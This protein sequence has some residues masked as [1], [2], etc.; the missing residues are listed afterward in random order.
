MY[1][2]TVK[3][4]ARGTFYSDPKDPHNTKT[5]HMWYSLSNGSSTSSYGFA[6]EVTE[7]DGPGKI[8]DNDDQAYEGTYYTGKIVIS[9][10]QYNKLKAFGNKDNLDGK[11]FDFSSYYNGLNNSCVDY[12][13]KA[14][15]I[16]GI[17]LSDFEG[18]AS[19][20]THNADSADEA[21]YKYLTG[22]TTGWDESRPDSGGYDVIYGSKGNDTLKSN[23][24]TDAIYG[25]SGNDDIYGNSTSEKLYGG[26]GADFIDGDSGND[27]LVGNG[28][29]D[30]LIGGKGNDTYI[31]ANGDTIMDSDHSGKVYLD[32]KWLLGGKL[33][34]GETNKYKGDYGEIYTLD[35]L[36]DTLHVKLNG[37]SITI[38]NYNE[39]KQSLGIS[40]GKEIEVTVGN[41]TVYED[42]GMMRVAVSINHILDKDITFAM[43]S[44]QASATESEDY[45]GFGEKDK[46]LGQVTIKAGQTVGY[47]DIP[48]VNDEIIEKDETFNIVALPDSSL[49]TNQ[50]PL[51]IKYNGDDLAKVTFTNAGVG[52]IQDDDKVI[53][54]IVDNISTCS[55]HV[56]QIKQTKKVA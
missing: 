9:Q 15:N 1:S 18:Q 13:W 6:P 25:G 42:A 7:M 47:I 53:F 22:S 2:V 52:T 41:S 51:S 27:T 12:V 19:F 49:D 26:D 50:Y 31:S 8:W 16:I 10:A 30:V 56:E 43:M 17:N 40:L 33:I 37:E 36:H 35:T 39:E 5:G 29:S 21:L 55:V 23:S 14:L 28:G 11:P 54:R 34:A 38:K 46:P 45:K 44:I 20:P 24:K 48:I 4:S 3:I 32:G